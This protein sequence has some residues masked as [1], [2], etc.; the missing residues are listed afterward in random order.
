M[1]VCSSRSV[2]VLHVSQR[3]GLKLNQAAPHSWRDLYSET[4]SSWSSNTDNCLTALRSIVHPQVSDPLLSQR[5]LLSFPDYRSVPRSLVYA[6]PQTSGTSP[7]RWGKAHI[8]SIR[9]TR[10]RTR[11]QERVTSPKRSQL[12]TLATLLR[13]KPKTRPDSTRLP[14]LATSKPP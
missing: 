6:R 10:S 12:K 9:W 8:H 13:Y 4:R 14:V 5:S 1:L 2:L 7:P 3:V 11:N